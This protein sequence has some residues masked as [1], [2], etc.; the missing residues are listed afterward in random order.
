MSFTMH[1]ASAPVFTRM[2]GH[3]LNWLDKAEAHAAARKFDPAN[4]LSARLAPDMLPFTKQIQIACDAAK[5]GV[6]RLAGVE[7]P[8]Y[9]DNEA[10]LADLRARVR[11]TLDFIASIPAERLA[12]S[13]E[14]DLVLP[15]RDGPVTLQGEFFLKH[16]ALPNFYFHLVTTYALLRHNGVDLGKAD[17]LGPLQ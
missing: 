1:S 13:D 10:S 3:L 5:F 12:G 14:R 7:A 17:Y 8:K 15:R 2:L 4:Y 16:Y 11:K 9:E 6:A